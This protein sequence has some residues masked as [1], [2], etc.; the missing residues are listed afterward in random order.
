MSIISLYCVNEATISQAYN[1][2]YNGKLRHISIQHGYIRGLIKNE[3]NV[4]YMT[5]LT[6][7]LSKEQSRDMVKKN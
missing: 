2:I 4:K 7:L 1:N 5:N 6:G 3:V